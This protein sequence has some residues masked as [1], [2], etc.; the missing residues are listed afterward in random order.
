M[1]HTWPNIQSICPKSLHS[2]ATL[3]DPMDH[4]PPVSSI[5]GILQAGGLKWAAFSFSKGYSQPSDQT[6]VSPLLHYQTGSLPLVPILV[7]IKF[8][9]V[10]MRWWRIPSTKHRWL[11]LISIRKY[12][13]LRLKGLFWHGS[14]SLGI[15]QT[16]RSYIQVGFEKFFGTSKR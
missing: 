9:W 11:L 7:S 5:H 2:W 3:R 12:S 13:T 1:E 16:R 15:I 6:F 4:S 8:N 14:K 10:P